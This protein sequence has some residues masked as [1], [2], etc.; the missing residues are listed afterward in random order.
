[1]TR[2]R[3]VLF[4]FGDTLF[5]RA[6][7]ARA[8]VETAAALGAEVDEARAASLW[9]RILTRAVSAEEMALARDRSAEAHRR[10]WTRLYAMAEEIAPGMAAALYAREI[11]ASRW[12]PHPDARSVLE[13]LRRAGVRIGVVSDTGWDIRPVFALAGFD[14]LVDAFVLSFEHGVVKPAPAL[15]TAACAALA[16]APAE[17]LMV[18]D[19]AV[20][21]GGAVRAGLTV[22]LLPPEAATR[23]RALDPVLHLVLER[24]G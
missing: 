12:T 19:N 24:A 13:R 21:D 22:L 8:V 7:G 23:P 16:I 5:A 11:D 15:F 1:M 4:D 14:R 2:F 3:A 20:T 10:E 17:T 18:G 9:R 6:G